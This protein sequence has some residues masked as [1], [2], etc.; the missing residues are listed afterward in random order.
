M[1]SS[2]FNEIKLKFGFS[3]LQKSCI[4]FICDSILLGL[5]FFCNMFYIKN[6]LIRNFDFNYGTRKL[7][8]GTDVLI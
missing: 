8:S 2:Q 6:A 1:A 5:R 4:F 7:P 3:A